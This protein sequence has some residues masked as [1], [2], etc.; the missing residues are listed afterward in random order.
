MQYAVDTKAHDAEFAA[1]FDVDVA[2]A[3]LEGVL[4]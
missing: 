2:G 1:R 3:L 4:P